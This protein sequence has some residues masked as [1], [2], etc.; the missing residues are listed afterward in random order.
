MNRQFVQEVT[1]T[2]TKQVGV[3]RS[4]VS[5]ALLL[6]LTYGLLIPPQ[7]SE[8]PAAYYQEHY[9]DKVRRF[10]NEFNERYLID[11]GMVIEGT[12]QVWL[13][14]YRANYIHDEGQITDFLAGNN[15][16][17]KYLMSMDQTLEESASI[18]KAA[19]VLY[20]QI[21]AYLMGIDK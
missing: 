1:A 7:I 17:R 19:A 16:G 18:A 10:V 20:P 9:E 4:A 13:D 2:L 12:R 21:S 14:R 11:V 8:D 15:P 5:Q 3:K 6:T